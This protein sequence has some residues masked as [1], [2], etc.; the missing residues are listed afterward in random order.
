VLN[1][2]LARSVATPT[3]AD[4]VLINEDDLRRGGDALAQWRPDVKG[5]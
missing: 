5:A 4:L 2:C 3:D 1:G